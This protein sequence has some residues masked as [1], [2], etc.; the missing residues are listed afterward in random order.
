MNPPPAQETAGDAAPYSATVDNS[1]LGK[2]GLSFAKPACTVCMNA[3]DCCHKTIACFGDTECNALQDC[4]GKCDGIGPADGGTGGMDNAMDSAVI[5]AAEAD[6][7]TNVYPSL[8]ATCASCHGQ[9]GGA[10]NLY[11]ADGY[12]TYAIFKEVGFDKPN[13]LLL[14]KGAHEGPALTAQQMDLINQWVSLESAGSS[15]A[16]GADGGADAS[17]H[18][19]AG[20]ADAG[21]A[22]GG[23]SVD[24]GGGLD[25]GG[26]DAGGSVDAGGADAGGSVNAGGGISACKNAC[27]ALHPNAIPTWESFEQC[28][29]GTCA[30]SCL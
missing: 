27:K 23:H 3:D 19:D 18:P 21:R 1:C 17:S 10:P 20:R 5:S 16:G 13:N 7:V 15:G 9:G 29:N 26:A 25:S 28:I 24:A 11:G 14:M 22:D 2:A 12:S 30:S 4:I 8:V 6:F